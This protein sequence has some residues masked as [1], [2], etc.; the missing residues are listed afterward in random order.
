M[1]L[2]QPISRVVR[3]QV[4]KRDGYVCHYCG[5]SVRGVR[6]HID[7]VVPVS[8]G[9]TND[10]ANLVTACVRCNLKK[11]ATVTGAWEGQTNAGREIRVRRKPDDIE[12]LR[13]REVELARKRQDIRRQEL[14]RSTYRDKGIDK[15][16]RAVAKKRLELEQQELA[17]GAKRDKSLDKRAK[18]L[19]KKRLAVEEQELQN[20]L[21]Q[22][23]RQNKQGGCCMF[24]FMLM[25][26]LPTAIS[27][28]LFTLV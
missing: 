13:R 8:W 28:L 18:E 14:D 24:P 19:E 25:L 23:K 15:Q 27:L 10:P 7:H 17:R 22:L 3:A 12:E 1:V 2:R 9:G 11:G 26:F 20:R 16:T 6:F 21:K 4:L 5:A